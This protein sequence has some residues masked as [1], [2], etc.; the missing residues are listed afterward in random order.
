M[1]AASAHLLVSGRVQ[2]VFYRAFTEE[3]AHKFG[4]KQEFNHSAQY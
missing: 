2:G 1:N 4:L 3:T